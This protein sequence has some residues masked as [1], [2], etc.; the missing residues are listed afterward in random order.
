[1]W[2]SQSDLLSA[3]VGGVSDSLHALGSLPGERGGA[4]QR[5]RVRVPP[6]ILGG[7]A[8]GEGRE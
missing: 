5:L 4:P 6:C 3:V 1:M 8:A 7:V 2:V